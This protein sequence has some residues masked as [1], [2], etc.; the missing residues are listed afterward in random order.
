MKAQR[1]G[2]GTWVRVKKNDATTLR[3][4]FFILANWE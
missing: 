4:L 2:S 3:N 1:L